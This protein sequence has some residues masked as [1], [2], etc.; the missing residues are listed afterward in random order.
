MTLFW[1]FIGIAYCNFFFTQPA[2]N[3]AVDGWQKNLDTPA[4][5]T[6]MCHTN[7]SM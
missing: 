4:L 2:N 3:K 5:R 6:Q 7:F 1:A